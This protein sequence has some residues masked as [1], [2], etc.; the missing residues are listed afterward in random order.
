MPQAAALYEELS[1]RANL[2]F[3]AS[4]CLVDPRTA[5]GQALEVVDLAARAGSPVHTLSGGLRQRL[6]LAC[7][8]VHQPDL[9]LLDEPT[10]GVDPELRASFWTHFRTLADGGTSILVSSH[11]MD[12]AERCDRLGLIREGV[13]LTEGTASSLRAETGAVTLEDAFLRLGRSPDVRP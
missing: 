10:V 12:E 1:V 13:L 2:H 6:S 3:F 9:L 4:L 7:A 11:V 5:V 8:L